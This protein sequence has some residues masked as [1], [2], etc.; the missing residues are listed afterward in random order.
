MEKEDEVI[1]ASP[2]PVA[3]H[4]LTF[5]RYCG[6]SGLTTRGRGRGAAVARGIAAMA[7]AATVRAEERKQKALAGD[8]LS[9]ADVDDL[10]MTA[11]KSEPTADVGEGQPGGSMAIQRS[12]SPLGRSSM[13]S[14]STRTGELLVKRRSMAP[15]KRARLAFLILAVSIQGS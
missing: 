3:R 8:G 14:G 11:E 12:P 1:P 9:P 15:K 7:A 5:K 2:E 10:A 6:A 13:L 4:G